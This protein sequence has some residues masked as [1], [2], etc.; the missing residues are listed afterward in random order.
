MSLSVWEPQGRETG[1]TA[2]FP[3]GDSGVTSSPRLCL[4]VSP[5]QREGVEAR[6]RTDETFECPTCLSDW[7]ESFCSTCGLDLSHEI[8]QPV[9]ATPSGSRA[10]TGLGGRV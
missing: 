4:G 8:N 10:A 7:A 5:R 1:V 3:A 2:P 6:S 9:A